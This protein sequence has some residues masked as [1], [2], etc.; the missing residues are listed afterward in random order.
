MNSRPAALLK[1]AANRGMA[2]D[3]KV[4][5]YNAAAAALRTVHAL[6]QDHSAWT[7]SPRHHA[8]VLE[9]AAVQFQAQDNAAY[10]VVSLTKKSH[11]RFSSNHSGFWP[12]STS[13]TPASCYE[14]L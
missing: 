14:I 2:D 1:L 12:E 11:T 9:A 13:Q 4:R 10:K 7:P 6:A 3:R 8:M 5:K